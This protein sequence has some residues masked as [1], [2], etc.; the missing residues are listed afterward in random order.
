[1]VF[2]NPIITKDKYFELAKLIPE[3]Q[4]YPV[5]KLDYSRENWFDI[6][7]EYVK[8]PAGRIIDYLG[9]LGKWEENVGVYDKHALCIVTNRKATGSQIFSLLEKIR[10]N[11]KE[12]YDVD[13]VYEINII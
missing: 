6:K 3:L 5:E 7:E 9:W 1:M 10:L 13:L 11:V 4:S 2:D 12:K 8:I